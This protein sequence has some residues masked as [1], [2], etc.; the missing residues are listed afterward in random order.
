MN[1][2]ENN[3]N[4]THIRKT[5]KDKTENLL[6]GCMSVMI[7][8]LLTYLLPLIIFKAFDFGMIFEIITLV[9]IVI[10]Y[11]KISQN[12]F[13]AVKKCII[14]AMIPIGWLIIYD[15]INLLAN[16][17]E[18][19]IEVFRYYF[20]FDQFFYYIEP[21]LVDVFL[22]ATIILL[23]KTYSALKK[24]EGSESLEAEDYGDTF[25]DKL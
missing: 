5:Y 9:F 10:A 13:K 18:V 23:Y 15:F 12:D 17:K 6:K 14:I 21:Y 2:I 24:A 20:S 3:E 22:V 11:N 7:V 16:I 25:Y 1:N 19:L 8:S 4:E